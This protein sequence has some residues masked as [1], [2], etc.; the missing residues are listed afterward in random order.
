[1]RTPCPVWENWVEFREASGRGPQSQSLWRELRSYCG[2][3]DAPCP[4]T[5]LPTSDKHMPRK[6]APSGPRL[7]METVLLGVVVSALCP[8]G[9]LP[10]VGP[11]LEGR[12]FLG[13]KAGG[14]EVHLGGG[15]HARSWEHSPEAISTG[16]LG[17]TRS[18]SH[19]GGEPSIRESTATVGNMAQRA[20]DGGRQR[21][22]EPVG[23][24]G[25][26]DTE[27]GLW[28]LPNPTSEEEAGGG[29]FKGPNATI[30]GFIARG[31]PFRRGGA[32]ASR[33]DA[34]SWAALQERGP[35]PGRRQPSLWTA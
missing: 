5:P 10:A 6:P 26:G 12:H 17:L 34:V 8:P 23:S 18:R 15:R 31:V 11:S 1:M 27:I 25:D 29:D 3:W 21:V 24:R 2:P 35:G 9:V 30:L 19:P 13:T 7:T 22:E 20:E 16:S 32:V 4:G 33:G 28:T 14:Q